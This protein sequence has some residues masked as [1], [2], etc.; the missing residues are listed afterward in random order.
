MDGS[1]IAQ[2]ILPHGTLGVQTI[3]RCAQATQRDAMGLVLWLPQQLLGA[4]GALLSG[5]SQ[6]KSKQQA[7]TEIKIFQCPVEEIEAEILR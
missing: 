7:E 1:L 5:V 3:G 2:T 6:C 4:K